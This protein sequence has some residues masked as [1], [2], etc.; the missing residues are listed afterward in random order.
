MPSQGNRPSRRI[1][2]EDQ[3]ARGDVAEP[4]MALQWRGQIPTQ[5][6]IECRKPLRAFDQ[7][8]ENAISPR[9]K[10]RLQAAIGSGC[11]L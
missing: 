6:L 2:Q 9:G 1:H 4:A 10:R 3:F 5:L 11:A 7:T 8:V